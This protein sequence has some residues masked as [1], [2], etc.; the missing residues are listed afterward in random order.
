M[1]WVLKFQILLRKIKINAI[2][3]PL[4][5][6]DLLQESELQLIKFVQEKMF[7]PELK[8]LTCRDKVVTMHRSSLIKQLDPFSNGNGIICIGGLPKI[9]FLNELSKQIFIFRK[10]EEV[11]NLIK[12]QCQIRCTH[13]RRSS[14]LH[15]LRSSGY[16]I[17]SCH[18]AV[19]SLL[20]K[21]VKCCRLQ[22]RPG[23]QRMADILVHRLPEVPH[24]TYGRVDM[25]TYL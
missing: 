23:K 19:T 22:S 9:L 6:G 16:W 12:Q 24:F 25:L 21:C 20:L 8:V 14:T 11:S 7:S 1:S 3:E 18:A 5:G 2:K 10:R 17:T 13:V 15:E 4:H